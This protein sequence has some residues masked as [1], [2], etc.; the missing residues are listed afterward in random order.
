MASPQ[1]PRNSRFK[2][3]FWKSPS[4]HLKTPA[5]FSPLDPRGNSTHP[6]GFSSKVPSYRK[7]SVMALA[8][9]GL[10][11][12]SGSTLG[13]TSRV[14]TQSELLRQETFNRSTGAHCAPRLCAK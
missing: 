3:T 13:A 1:A 6:S 10:T 7:P 4:V 12:P 9:M 11:E 8:R 5:C 14:C 2:T